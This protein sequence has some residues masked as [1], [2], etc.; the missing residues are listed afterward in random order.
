M[1]NPLH[2]QF[3]NIHGPIPIKYPMTKEEMLTYIN[4]PK[5]SS[6]TIAILW[7]TQKI[8]ENN[9]NIQ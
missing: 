3:M 6:L 4:D 9:V 7:L 1:N 2:D 5:Q 8:E